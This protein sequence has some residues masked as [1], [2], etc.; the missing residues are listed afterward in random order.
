MSYASWRVGEKPMGLRRQGIRSAASV[1]RAWRE[2]RTARRTANNARLVDRHTG[3]HAQNGTD[4][5]HDA[6]PYIRSGLSDPPSA[7]AWFR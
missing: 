6:P 2:L 1:W 4:S 5:L 7:M 3:S